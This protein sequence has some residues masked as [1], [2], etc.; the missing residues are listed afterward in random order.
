MNT[1]R[2]LILASHVRELPH[3]K[4]NSPEFELISHGELEGFDMRFVAAK[5]ECGTVGCLA[6]YTCMLF[7][8][9]KQ[10]SIALATGLL[11]LT[12][13]ESERLFSPTTPNSDSDWNEITPVKAADACLQLADGK[14]IDWK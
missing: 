11:E 3:S 9:G 4:T 2:L 13:Q 14:E 10:L 8:K 12:K 5:T 7:A 6:G 1:E